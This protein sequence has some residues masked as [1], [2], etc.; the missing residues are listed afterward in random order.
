M[1]V[2]DSSMLA[3][4]KLYQASADGNN[5][6][7]SYYL[8]GGVIMWLLDLYVISHTD[9][10]H[11][12]D[13][14]LRALW[15]RYQT[16]PVRGLSEE[17][18]IAIMERA[19]GVQFREMLLRWLDGT[20]ELPIDEVLGEVGYRLVQKTREPEEITFGEKRGFAHV[21]ADVFVGWTVADRAGDVVVRQVEDG[22]PAQLAGIGIDDELISI[23]GMR[24]T[25][26]AHLVQ[27]L[28][29]VGTKPAA[30]LAQCDGRMYET[31][32]TAVAEQY[33]TIE[34]VGTPTAQQTKNQQVWLRRPI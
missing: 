22:S 17:E 11:T 30:L 16:D 33:V 31:V 9:G 18:T 19:T 4:V 15:Q 6:F 13:D 26:T 5:R 29:S 25:S 10:A 28:A 32:V 23:S 21:P 14:A 8:K 2:R 12:L 3:W 34:P 20:E 24:I 7:P 27:L 1:S